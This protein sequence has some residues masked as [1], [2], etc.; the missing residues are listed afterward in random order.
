MKHYSS[1][2]ELHRENNFPAPE[3]PLFS[4]FEVDKDST[5]CLI[6]NEEF[7]SDFYML[8]FKKLKAG[9]IMYGRTKYDHQAGSMFFTQPR[10]VIKMNDLEFEENGFLIFFHEDFLNGNR[11]H[12]EIKHYGYFNYEVNEALHLSPKEEQIIWEF[13]RKLELEYFN[14]QDEYSRDILLSNINSMLKY[15]QRFYKR[16]FINRKEISGR[17]VSRFND[18]LEKYVADGLLQTKGLPSVFYIAEQ[19]FTSPR[20]LSDLIKQETGKTTIELIHI[21]LISEAKNLLRNGDAQTVTEIAYA[22]GFENIFYFSRLFK[23][24]VGMS[25]VQFKKQILN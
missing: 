12:E 21:Y 3:N 15:A 11:L 25:P 2:I 14:N 9:V 23:R 17:M 24:E 1:L 10:Q 22:L 4:L 7:T 20:Y 18:A 16:Q 19:L 13:Y 8:A 6:G 5:N